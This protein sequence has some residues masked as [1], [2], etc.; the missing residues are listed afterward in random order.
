MTYPNTP[1]SVFKETD[2][3]VYA[4]G[5]VDDRDDDEDDE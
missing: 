2:T 1:L 3:S 4:D 5:G